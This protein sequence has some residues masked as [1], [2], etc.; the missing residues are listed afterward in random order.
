MKT[1]LTKRICWILQHIKKKRIGI[2]AERGKEIRCHGTSENM[3]ATLRFARR[4][5]QIQKVARNSFQKHFFFASVADPGVPVERDHVSAYVNQKQEQASAIRL[6]GDGWGRVVAEGL[7]GPLIADFPPPA[8]CALL[9]AT[10]AVGVR[11]PGPPVHRV[12]LSGQ[13]IDRRPPYH[14]LCALYAYSTACIFD[15]V[16]TTDCGLRGGWVFFS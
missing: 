8:D 10:R 4:G 3:T 5:E 15:V 16:C 11:L 1:T 7:K 13:G 14:M 12:R 9:A 6:H 2:G